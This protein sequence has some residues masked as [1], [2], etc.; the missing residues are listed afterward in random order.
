MKLAYDR[1]E[2]GFFK[3]APVLHADSCSEF[4]SENA[5]TV[6]FLP[7]QDVAKAARAVGL[8]PH[9]CVP[10]GCAAVSEETP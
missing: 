9:V 8:N 1:S 5:V 6:H 7:G 3:P 2:I 4:P 10:R